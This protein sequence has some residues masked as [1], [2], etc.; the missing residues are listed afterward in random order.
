MGVAIARVGVAGVVQAE[1]MVHLGRG[2]RDGRRVDPDVAV[3]VLLHQGAGVTGVALQVQHPAG[4]G[5]QHRVVRHHLVGGNTDHGLG[6]GVQLGADPLGLAEDADGLHALGQDFASDLLGFFGLHGVR[7]RMGIDPARGIHGAGIFLAPFGIRPPALRG[8]KG[9]ATDIAHIAQL[10]AGGGTLGDLDQGALGVAEQ[11]D[12]GLGIDQ[13]GLAHLVAPVVV[14]GDAAQTGLDAAD[15]DLHTGVG[16]A[17]ALRVDGDGAVG[18]L[19]RRAVRGVGVVGAGFAISRVAVDHRIHIA[20]SDAEEEARPTQRLEGFGT[21]PG[22]LGD[23]A[24]AQALRFQKA[25]DQG[26]A[27]ARM[28][29]IAVAADQDDVALVPAQGIH[30]GAAHGQHGRRPARLYTGGQFK[31]GLGAVRHGSIKNLAQ[32]VIFSEMTAQVC[33]N[34][35]ISLR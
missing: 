19:V 6:A 9:G 8:D 14:L 15:H 17:A 18:A 5:V 21:V 27:E 7:V 31:D 33:K 29:D 24:H 26:H 25:A 11:E 1:D 22:R 3:T 16:F 10:L 13:G 12:V 2:E 34:C 35:L 23:D 4:M 32:S 28:V 30:L 20:G